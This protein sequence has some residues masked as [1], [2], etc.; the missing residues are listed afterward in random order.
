MPRPVA[1]LFDLDDTILEASSGS[2]PAWHAVAGEMAA[3]LGDVGPERVV[4]AI[5]SIA[6]HYWSDPERHRRGRLDLLGTR[7]RLVAEAL[8]LLGLP[9]TDDL[10]GRFACR[11]AEVRQASLRPFPGALETLQHFRS[12]G[13]RL[14]L[15]TNGSGLEQRAKIEGFGLQPC[16]DCIVVEGEFGMGK[17]DERVFR[18]ALQ[19]LGAPRTPETWM[20]G[21][22]L[23][24]EIAPCRRLGLHTV[25]VDWAGAGL[26]DPC[27]VEPDRTV[28]AICE[29]V[30]HDGRP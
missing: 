5:R 26:P 30:G 24:W 9:D 13:V 4:A 21:D 8:Q 20:V 11:Y 7:R 16:F 14:A 12:L 28:R 6:D 25:W 17:P 23:V 22:N 3:E 10:W 27:P 1:I 18:H 2:T 29:L 15:V 19:A